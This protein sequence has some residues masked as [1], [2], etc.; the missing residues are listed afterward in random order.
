MGNVEPE[1]RAERVFLVL[2][3]ENS[4]GDV[5]AATGFGAGIPTAPPLD[6][7]EKDERDER[8]RPEGFAGESVRKV[9]E[10]GKRIC[11]RAA[12]FCSFGADDVEAQCECADAADFRD[13]DPGEHDD[14]AH[15][16]DELE[17]IGDEHTPKAANKGVNTGERNQDED[18][19]EQRG[20]MRFAECVMK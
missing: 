10:E 7:E 13:G 19:D 8:D 16:E 15:F 6:A 2:R 9:G 20:V 14:H 12:R 4:L 17:K 5:A 11:D 1:S 3:G 18:A